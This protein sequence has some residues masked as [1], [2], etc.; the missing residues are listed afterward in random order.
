MLYM[1]GKEG[2]PY[3]QTLHFSYGFGALLA[4]LLASP[5]LSV[6]GAT[7]EGS[8][9]NVTSQQ[10]S[11]CVAKNLSIY[12]PYTLMGVFC[13][14]MALV[15]AYLSFFHAQTDE[16]SSRLKKMDD[17]EGVAKQLIFARRA[18][19][20]VAGL[21]VFSLLGFEIGMGTFITSFA[22]MSDHHLTTQV[23]AYM[24]SIYWATFTFFRLFAIAYIKRISIYLNITMELCILLMA[25]IFLVPFGNSVEWCLWVGIA[26]TGVGMSTMWASILGLIESHFPLTSGATSFL[27]IC[28]CFGEWFYPIF[29]GY[30]F[31]TSPQ[32]YL[33]TIFVCTVTCCI[34]FAILCLVLRTTAIP[35]ESVPATKPLLSSPADYG[36]TTADNV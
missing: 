1:W 2:Q 4:P 17:S 36:S 6:G 23:G 5:F 18:V 31:E 30:A 21:F 20:L 33:W 13:L 25:N 34:I 28:A 10:A 7:I 29:M 22:V 32:L 35:S 16:H 8:A 26:L 27:A 14:C 24:T 15:F 19:V 12:I 11:H 3:L 9:G